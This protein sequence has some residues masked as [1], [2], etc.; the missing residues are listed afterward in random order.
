MPIRSPIPALTLAL[1]AQLAHAR[2]GP[3]VLLTGAIDI[4]NFG[5][6]G[7]IRAYFPGTSTCNI[8]D[9]NLNW[10]N[11]NTPVLAPNAYRLH[12]GRLLHIGMGWCR[13]ACCSAPSAG[14]GLSCNGAGGDVLGAGCREVNSAGF[15]GTQSRLTARSRINAFTGAIPNASGSGADTISRRLQIAETDLSAAVFPGALYFIE[16]VYVSSDDADSSNA[17]NN[18]SHERITVNQASFALVPTGAPSPG[19]PAIHAWHDHGLG[20]GVPDPRVTLQPIDIPGEGRYWLAAKV[21]ELSKDRFLYDYALFNLNS[22]AAIGSFRVP[23][24]SG[25]SAAA[26]GFHDAISHSGEPYD[27]TDWTIA[28]SSSAVTWSTPQ[29]FAQNPN[30][31]ALRWGAMNNF[32]FESDTPPAPARVTIH[33]FKPHSPQS[34]TILAPAPGG[35]CPPD[36]ND[37]G[38]ITSQD[39]FDFLASFFDAAADF[40]ADGVTNSQDFFDFLSAFFEGC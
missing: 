20:V 26:A 11:L 18:A 13:T 22:D 23:L 34:I 6:I 12:N 5:A 35:G 29:T 38:A 10:L 27:N 7:G 31:S 32:W 28:L 1:L 3:D 9:A 14:C 36:W 25:S 16:G 40:N 8:G 21:T 15:G 37:D 24:S 17:L 2:P 33:L 19:V 39:F 30:S 4:T